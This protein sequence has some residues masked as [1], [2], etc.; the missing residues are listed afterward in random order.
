M[1]TNT[2]YHVSPGDTIVRNLAGCQHR[3]VVENVTDELIYTFGGWTFDRKTG[4]EVDEV[5]D[6][7]PPPKLTGS[8]IESVISKE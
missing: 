7:G 5:C 3:I 2:F 8:Y 4:A 1:T 6:W